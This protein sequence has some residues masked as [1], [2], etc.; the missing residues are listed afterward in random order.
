MPNTTPLT[1]ADTTTAVD[2]FMAGLAHPHKAEVQ[3]LRELILA[4]APQVAEGIKWN[5]PS[6][7]TDQYFATTNLRVKGGVGII[8]HLGAKVRATRVLIDDPGQLLTWHGANR[9]S[10]DVRDMDELHAR[11]PALRAILAQWLPHV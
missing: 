6:Y 4:S 10:F 11:T 7:R 3:A 1:A 9:A 8:L 5:A 2:A